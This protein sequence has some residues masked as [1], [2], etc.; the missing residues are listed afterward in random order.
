MSIYLP[1]KFINKICINYDGNPLKIKIPPPIY[2]FSWIVSLFM[3]RLQNVGEDTA[4]EICVQII[5]KWMLEKQDVKV[6][7]E[8]NWIKIESS[9]RLMIVVFWTEMSCGLV[10]GY[11]HSLYSNNGN[12]A[13]DVVNTLVILSCTII[14]VTISSNIIKATV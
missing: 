14:M 6:W 12:R 5:L 4:W 2:L 11:Q 13:T 7:A 9:G 10:G 1:S 8:L 3:N